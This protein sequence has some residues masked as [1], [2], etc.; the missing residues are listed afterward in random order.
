MFFLLN[1]TA[2]SCHLFGRGNIALI[3]QNNL[4]ARCQFRRKALE[5]FVDFLKI[6]YGVASFTARNIHH[7]QKQT[8]AVYMAQKSVAQADAFSCTLD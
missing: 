7:M 3:R 6:F 5:F 4:R 2:E 1:I 8:A